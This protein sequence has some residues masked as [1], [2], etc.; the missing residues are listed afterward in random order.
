MRLYKQIGSSWLAAVYF[1]ENCFLPLSQT[2]GL[3]RWFLTSPSKE[4]NSKVFFFSG[5]HTTSSSLNVALPEW[6]NG[7]PPNYS[8]LKAFCCKRGNY[9]LQKFGVQSLYQWVYLEYLS[10]SVQSTCWNERC[11]EGPGY[12][13]GQKVDHELAECSCGGKKKKRP[14]VSWGVLK[15]L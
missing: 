12:P 11:R 1:T 5:L 14:M 10:P 13:G 2:S 6:W 4:N 8:I 9:R 3:E 7:K 15:R